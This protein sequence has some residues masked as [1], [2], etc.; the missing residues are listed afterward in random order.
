MVNTMSM[1]DTANG[2]CRSWKSVVKGEP[3]GTPTPEFSETTPGRTQYGFV[4]VK[5]AI[6]ISFHK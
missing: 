4:F 6:S 3:L 2:G 1:G 5:Y